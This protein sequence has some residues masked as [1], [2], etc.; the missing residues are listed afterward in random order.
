MQS[1][2]YEEKFM[3]RSIQQ[4]FTLIELMI[5]VAIIGIL[6]AVALPAYQDYTKRARVSEGLVQ[7]GA[8][9]QNVADI[10]A[11]GAVAADAE[12]YGSGYVPPTLS[13][14][15][16]GP[17]TA[18]DP[19]TYSNANAAASA[20]I[21]IDPATGDISIPY[22]TRIEVAAS[23]TLVLVP[24]V[25]AANGTSEE[26]LPVGTDAFTPPTD[27]VKWKCR[28][29]GATSPFKI[30]TFATEP[31]LPQKLAPAECR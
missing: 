4:G 14:N 6:A 29:A 7:A 8:A 31:T 18:P 2:P 22:S 1:T 5:V 25:G 12:G 9:K 16:I 17:V 13:D 10:V 15:V 26:R 27:A 19:K 20:G 3:K 28:A 30:A 23:N 11:K 21:R 24:Y